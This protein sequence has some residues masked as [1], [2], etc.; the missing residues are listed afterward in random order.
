M[1]LHVGGKKAE[2]RGERERHTHTHTH[3][4]RQREREREREKERESGYICMCVFFSAL[5]SDFDLKH[6]AID[7]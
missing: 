1:C 4:H 5:Y 6:Q 2:G 3:T 7:L